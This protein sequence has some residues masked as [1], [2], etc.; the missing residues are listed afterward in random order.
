MGVAAITVAMLVHSL[1]VNSLLLPYLMEPL[2]L[3]WG[4]A[5]RGVR[6]GRSVKA[7]ADRSR[8]AAVVGPRIAVVSFPA[9]A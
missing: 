1:F 2:W 9:T 8:L 4:G 3:L 7:N 6:C 5:I